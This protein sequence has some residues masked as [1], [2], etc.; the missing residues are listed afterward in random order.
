MPFVAVF[1][2]EIRFT[3][4]LVPSQPSWP[5]VVVSVLGFSAPST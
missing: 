2:T 4:L 3:V 1:D 5:G